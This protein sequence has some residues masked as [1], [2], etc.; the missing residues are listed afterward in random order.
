[1]TD[2]NIEK[3]FKCD[4]CEYKS[5]NKGDLKKHV[6]IVHDQIKDI[7]CEKC[8]YICSTI[9]NLK[10]H[11]KQ[12]HDRIKDVN[13]DICEYV[14]STNSILKQHVKQKHE[15]SNESLLSRHPTQLYVG[16][17]SRRSSLLG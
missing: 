4:Q 6:K 3:T 8:D 5:K 9:T 2:I 16:S 14:C 15:T 12:I 7:K 10:Q 17:M 1:M 11:I 13:C